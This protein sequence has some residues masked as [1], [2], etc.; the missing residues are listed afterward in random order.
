MYDAVC[1]NCGNA[2]QIPFQ[3][4]DGRPV[5]C[6][7]CFEKN[8]D[9][10]ARRPEERRPNNDR[11]NNQAQFDALN[12]KL[13]TILS[14]LQ[15]SP[16]QEEVA[17]LESI[18]DDSVIDEIVEEIKEQKEVKAVKTKTPAK[19]KAAPKKAKKTSKK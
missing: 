4:R 9:S 7:R 1:S 6:S 12:A 19:A 16:V 5:F 10:G 8:E 3:P 17:P 15:K 2:C 14:L 11:P 18:I 13:D